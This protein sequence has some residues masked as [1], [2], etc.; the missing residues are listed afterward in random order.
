M[1]KHRI[2]G[3]IL[4]IL[5]IELVVYHLVIKG[6]HSCRG[7]R[8]GINN[9][10]A[11][12]TTRNLMRLSHSVGGVEAAQVERGMTEGV[13]YQTEEFERGNRR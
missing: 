8:R 4:Q 6:M 3:S 2:R 13:I 1:G 9:G 10:S 11:K 5:Q 12:Q 7:K